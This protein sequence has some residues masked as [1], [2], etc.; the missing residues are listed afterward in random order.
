[1]LNT[2]SAVLGSTV[3]RLDTTPGSTQR[4][5]GRPWQRKRE[6]LFRSEP[7]CRICGAL[8]RVS[9]ATEVDHVVP[10][11]EGG[12]NDDANLQPIC[13]DCHKAKTAE[14]IRRAGGRA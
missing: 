4:E 14:E 5:A 2:R 8:G 1:M 7:L 10:L 11:A 12:S 6:R 13:G 3:R 9:L